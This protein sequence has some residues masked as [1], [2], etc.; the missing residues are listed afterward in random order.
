M[1]KGQ[2]MHCSGEKYLT[3]DCHICGKN[4]KGSAEKISML[5]KLHYK[6]AHKILYNRASYDKKDCSQNYVSAYYVNK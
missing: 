4:F 2:K 6:V 5:E 1:P 3:A